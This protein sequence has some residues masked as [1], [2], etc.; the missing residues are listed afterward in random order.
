MN[1][2]HGNNSSPW[3]DIGRGVKVELLTLLILIACYVELTCRDTEV[4][5]ASSSKSLSCEIQGRNSM[6]ALLLT[7]VLQL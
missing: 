5:N 3:G 6:K 7:D 4:S 2:E 1:S